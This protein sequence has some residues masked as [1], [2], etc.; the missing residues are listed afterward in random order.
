MTGLEN[1]AEIANIKWLRRLVIVLLVVMIV[2]FIGLL[3]MFAVRL[4]A[5]G[6]GGALGVPVGIVLPS[7]RAIAVT[8]TDA[9]WIV[10]NDEGKVFVY[11]TEDFE[12]R[13]VLTI[14]DE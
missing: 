4:S 2:G 3:G 5:G 6:G 14:N 10:L 11:D 7:G 13:K 1:N 8:Q 12:L 9:F